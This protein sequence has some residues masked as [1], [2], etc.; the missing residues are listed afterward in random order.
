VENLPSN[1]GTLG[2]WVLE[3]FAM[4]TTRRTDRQ[5]DGRTKA[6]LIAPLSAFQLRSVRRSL[7]T[8][9]TRALVQAFISCRLDYCN[10]VMAGVPDV[11]LQR[12]QSLQNAA[13]RLVSGA[14]RHD[15]I[16]PVL[17]SLHWLPVRQRISYKTAVLVWKCLHDAA[18]RYLADL[19]VLAHSV[20]G[21][22]QLRSTASGTLLVPRARTATGQRNGPRT[23]NSLPADLRTLDMTVLF[24]ASSQ[25]TPVSAVVYAAADWWLSTVRPVP[26]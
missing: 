19:C 18:P 11:Y 23:W 26:L 10:S 6:T 2:L 3:L 13:A 1:W 14:C 16:T 22:Q 17:V 8:E 7:T 5:T 24:Q 4:Y 15:H 20:R 25:D 21:R 9:A 12:L